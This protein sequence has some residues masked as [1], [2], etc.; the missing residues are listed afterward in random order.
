MPISQHINVSIALAEGN[1]AQ[2]N[3]GDLMFVGDHDVNATRI[4]GPYASLAAVVAAGFTVADEPEIH[5]WATAV[6][7]QRPR[8][9]QVFI[10][11]WDTAA[12]TLVAALDAIE[13]AD[14]SIGYCFNIASRATANIMALA[15]WIEA[16]SKI[17]VTQNDDAGMLAGTTSTAQNVDITLGGTATDGAYRTTVVNDWTGATVADVTTTRSAGSPAT[18]ALIADAHAAALEA[19]TALAAITSPIAAVGAVI[20]VDFTGL[21]NHYSFTTTA[22]APATM[23]AADIAGQIQNA[24]Q[25]LQAAGFDRTAVIYHDDDTEYLDGAWSARCLGFNLDAP[26]GAGTWSYHELNGVTATRLT[27]AQKSNLTDD[28][29]NFYSPVRYTSGVEEAGFTF[30]GVMASG[31]FI[32]ITTTIDITQARMEEAG[33]AVFLL[34]ASSNRKVPYT[35]AGI[36]MFDSAFSSVFADLTKAG[37]F[38]A[39]ATS[40]VSGEITP[41]VVVPLAAEVSSANKSLRRLVMSAEAVLAGAI[42][43]VGDTATVGFAITLNV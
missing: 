32:D 8:C 20:S 2:A 41:R 33:L 39:G 16:R 34:A 9:S 5:A 6:F 37:H 15:T 23:V 43:S 36:A 18:L 11:L 24:A 13:A 19:V 22:P 29:A 10:G 4:N 21:G 35:D 1:S 40:P 28:G 14:P 38:A 25:L 27:D 12:E 7:S 42:N 31:R 30:P 3:F 26:S 17:A